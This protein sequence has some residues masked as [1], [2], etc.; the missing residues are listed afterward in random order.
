MYNA[1]QFLHEAVAS[2]LGQTYHDFELI[3]VDDSS[4]DNSLAI[5]QSFGDPRI[6]IIKHNINLGP[7]MSRNHALAEARGEF[8]AIMDSDDVC[9]PTR[10]KRQVGFL[11]ANPE[12]GL[13][14]CGIY[15][16][17]DAGGAVLY[18]SYLPQDNG[19][20]QRTIVER[21]CFLH[22]SIMFRRE[23]YETVGGYR[24]IFRSAEDHD[25]ILR[26]L[27][28]CEA[29]NLYERLVSYRLNPKG[30]SVVDHECINELGKAAM[31]L[32]R[33]RRAG[34]PED[35]ESEISLLRE[36]MKGRK[37]ARSLGGIVQKWRDSF[38][39]ADRYYGFGC[40]ELC[41]GRLENA[42]RCFVRSLR[43]NGLF[44]KSWIGV[45]LSLM[46]PVASRLKV[47]FRS[48]MQHEF[49]GLR[50]VS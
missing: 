48:S 31:R 5:V 19:T 40:L 20:I 36:P 8:V 4:N 9:V 6:R 49:S 29:H 45:I 3:V 25:F 33:R 17:I 35:L 44:V 38:Y 10:L 1:A 39:A 2:V 23:V 42:R 18:T 16:N 7:A 24:E 27:E 11:D 13:V 28:H 43:T 21:W 22:P 26:M 32:A 37:A 12:I 47:V 15:D 50:D 41:A 34:Q 14:G 30:L 46:P